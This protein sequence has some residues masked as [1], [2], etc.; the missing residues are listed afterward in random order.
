ML[1]RRSFLQS[2]GLLSVLP[3]SKQSLDI[4]N[5]NTI[6]YSKRFKISLNAY[7]FNSLLTKQELSLE[8]LIDFCVAEGFDAVDLTGYYFPGYP[9][10]PSNDYI[11]HIKN[12]LHRKGLSLSGTGIRTDF[13]NPDPKE[14]QK[15]IALT[16]RWID[17][18]AK[19]GA[20][21]LRIFSG[22][23]QPTGY[24]WNTVADWIIKDFAV[25]VDYAKTKGVIIGLQNHNDFIKTA[26]QSLYFL[27]RLDKNWFG[28][29]LDIGSF[30]NGD[31]YPEIEAV[32]PYAVNWQLKELVLQN[33]KSVPVDLKKLFAIIHKSN[34]RGYLPIET[35]RPDNPF[36]IVPMFLKKVQGSIGE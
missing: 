18:A 15:D 11:F 10:V 35:L 24:D 2:I 27:E 19:L 17:V 32:I 6:R 9:A 7:S 14:R 4:N 36:D 13:T 12:T 22:K 26:A 31:P 25:C 5:F 21:V 29:V 3:L 34:Y 20:P 16:K 1:H 23:Q 30:N 28:L 8:R 33:G